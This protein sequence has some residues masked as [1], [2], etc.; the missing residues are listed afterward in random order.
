MKMK[1][2]F[3]D[4]NINVFLMNPPASKS[5]TSSKHG[6]FLIS[7]KLHIIS[8][9]FWDKY[10][11]GKC[12]L[13]FYQ[14][15]IGLETAIMAIVFWDFIFYHNF[16]PTR[17]KQ[18]VD[19]SNKHLKQIV[20]ISNKHGS[21]KHKLPYKLP[22]NLRLEILGNL[23]ISAK[24]QNVRE[25]KPSAQSSSQNENF[26]NTS[27]KFPKNRNLTFSLVHYFT[28]NLKFIL[29]ILSMTTSETTFFASNLP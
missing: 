8:T 3:W 6:K 17:L 11:N 1:Y 29:N 13:Q 14:Y 27:K 28:W 10:R 4:I 18:N 23:E 15:F 24:S 7:L 9:I 5:T 21:N 16:L 26:V 20:V 19:I 12:F 25:L 2:H 22:N